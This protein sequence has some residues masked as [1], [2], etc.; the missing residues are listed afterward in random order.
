MLRRSVGSTGAEEVF[1]STHTSSLEHSTSN[2]PMVDFEVSVQPVLKTSWGPPKH[3]LWNKVHL[4]HRC[5]AWDHRFNRWYRVTWLDFSLHPEEIGRQGRR[6]FRQAS[7][8]PMLRHRLN[9][10]CSFSWFS[11]EL[12][13]SWMLLRLFLLPS[14]LL[15]SFDYLELFLSE[16]ARSLKAN[17]ILVKLLTHEP[18]LIVRSRIKNYKT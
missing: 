4:L 14:V 13:W 12:T 2:A 1:T 3:A 6:N 17:S 9:R 16:C 10:C 7:D 8:A 5:F 15:T 18:L 11:A